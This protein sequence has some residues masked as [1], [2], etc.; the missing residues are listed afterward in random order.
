M[1]AYLFLTHGDLGKTLVETGNFI[2]KGDFSKQISVLS[3]DYS[4]VDEMER[5]QI[6]MEKKI[7][8]FLKSGF[9]VVIFVD[10]FG[11]SPSNIAFQFSK[12]ENVD[13][14]S[15]VNLPLTLY[16]L[17]HINR[18]E[19]LEDFVGGAIKTC[20]ESI[21]GVNDLLNMKKEA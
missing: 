1:F 21:I 11:G 18:D 15:G 14:I 5:I 10:V 13:I 3:I 6:E 20:R 17:D 19:P 2:I 16:A 8:E 7:K 12:T 9:K 4:M